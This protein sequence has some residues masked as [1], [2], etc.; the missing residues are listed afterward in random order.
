MV[1]VPAGEFLMGTSPDQLA[2]CLRELPLGE[3]ERKF[4]DE[5]PQHK[6]RLD[7]YYIYKTEVTIAQ[8]QKFCPA[9]GRGVPGVG[10]GTTDAHPMLGVSWEDADAYAKWAEA[11]LL[12]MIHRVLHPSPGLAN[13]AIRIRAVAR[14]AKPGLG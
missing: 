14:M 13:R 11:S 6:V 5:A 9:V 7:A 1:L 10:E 2:A 8:Y 12:A 4:N 3:D